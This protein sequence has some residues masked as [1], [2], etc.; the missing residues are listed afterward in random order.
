MHSMLTSL[1]TGAQCAAAFF[2]LFFICPAAQAQEAAL[3]QGASPP[4]PPAEEVLAE[5]D[6]QEV[7]AAE[8]EGEKLA[9][10]LKEGDFN[11]NFRYRYEVVDQDNFDL[12]AY[13]STLR[14]VLNYRTA[15]YHGFDLFLEAENVAVLGD[16]KYNNA[17]K[18]GAGN[19]VTDRPVVADPAGTAMNQAY[20]RYRGHDTSIGGG[21]QEIIL[22]D[23]RY[24]GAVG[25]RQNHQSFDS[26]WLT[27]NS[28]NNT[29]IRY[30]YIGR[31]NRIFRDQQRMSTHLLDGT[32]YV[33]GIGDL[34]VYGYFLDFDNVDLHKWSTKTFGFELAGSREL[35]LGPSILYEIEFAG[36]RDFGNNPNRVDAGY[37]HLMLGGGYEGFTV[38]LGYESLGGN[39]DEGQF[40]TPLAT[41]H[42]FNGWADKFLN[43]PTNGLRDFYVS[44]GGPGGP[45]SWAV[46]FHNFGSNVGGI[47]Y[48]TELDFQATYTASWKQGFGLKG[49][50]YGAD[51]FSTDT[52]KFWI[53]T[54]YAF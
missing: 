53:W 54:T 27:N 45:I 17:G 8:T 38:K 31:A 42:K 35:D 11:V 36:Q 7:E 26:L 49:A 20:L 4:S 51:E 32:I 39:E 34:S 28:L 12:N 21:R 37:L 24:V 23:Q 25:W 3:V 40:S 29:T 22:R 48:G 15:A 30:G 44:A 19:G 50:Y 46:A 1:R 14:T 47:H 5:D 43:T 33:S 52:F 2:V 41:L 10:A 6:Q 16:D 13:A 9:R 18:D